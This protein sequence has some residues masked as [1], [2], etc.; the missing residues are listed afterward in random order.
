MNETKRRVNLLVSGNVQGVFFRASTMERAQSL[1]IVGWVC[2]LPE[3]CVEIEAEGEAY[4]LE[5]LIDWCK[6]GPPAADVKTV[7]VR[8]KNFKGEFETFKIAS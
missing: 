6:D 5:E 3:G 8:W 7:D 4:A 1:N 2:N